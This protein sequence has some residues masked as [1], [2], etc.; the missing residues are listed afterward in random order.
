MIVYVTPQA[1]PSITIVA[2]LFDICAMPESKSYLLTLS[3][4]VIRAYVHISC[5]KS[6]VQ[7]IMKYK[8]AIRTH[9]CLHGMYVYNTWI[10]ME[11][12]NV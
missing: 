5:Y 4:N 1:S 7:G 8:H 3:E 11:G 6:L 10:D 12:C 9:I 2:V